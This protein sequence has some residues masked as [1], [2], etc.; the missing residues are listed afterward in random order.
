MAFQ[1]FLL[2]E[3]SLAR[4]FVPA[5][6]ANH[7]Q[8]YDDLLQLTFDTVADY[9]QNMRRPGGLI[10]SPQNQAVLI[11]N[12]GIPITMITERRLSLAVFAAHY[13]T[14]IG[15]PLDAQNMVWNRFQHF[16]TFLDI[17]K[18]YLAPSEPVEHHSGTSF[19]TTIELVENHLSLTLG[20]T[21]LPLSYVVRHDPDVPLHDVHPLS[22][23]D[24][25]PFASGSFS[26]FSEELTARTPHTIPEWNTDNSLVFALL[27]RVFGKSKYVSS[28]QPYRTRNDGRAA[29]LALVQHNLGS[30]QWQLM[31][32]DAETIVTTHN[33]FGT[34][35]HYTL[36]T[37]I[38]KH[39]SAHDRMRRASSHVNFSLPTETTRVLRLLQSLETSNIAI[40]SAKT[41]ILGDDVKRSDFE[42]TSDFL[43]TVTPHTNQPRKSQRIS[44]LTSRGGKGRNNNYHNNR[45]KNGKWK[46]N[47]GKS[48]NRYQ[49]YNN[50]D[51]HQQQQHFTP[52]LNRGS[53]GVEFRYYTDSDYQQLSHPQRNELRLWRKA[54]N[55]PVT[56]AAI[57]QY[58]Q[59][60]SPQIVP[61]PQLP[62]PPA[63]R[64]PPPAPAHAIVPFQYPPG[65]NRPP[66]P[67]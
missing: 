63:A 22:P 35:P 64:V 3:L 1:Q 57:Q 56:I 36:S 24:T 18:N 65:Q 17:R 32:H 14:L 54:Q 44:S 29:Y 19:A 16:A 9:C 48:N 66:S 12:P 33:F 15:R 53:S 50:S 21:K 7:L 5:I 45:G 34:N 39:R 28:L 49:P 60:P 51:H 23:N 41:S 13:Y 27:L 26:G 59:H 55:T 10:P 4:A 30:N 25:L 67:S 52:T 40:L 37:H 62:P 8:S 46:S 31:F 2:N 61:H 58:L 38:A 42:L 43:I 20:A 6:T 11:P 47:K